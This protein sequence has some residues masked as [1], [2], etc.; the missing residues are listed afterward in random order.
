VNRIKGPPINPH[1]MVIW[2][3][4][5]ISS[6]LLSVRSNR[7]VR[8]QRSGKGIDFSFVLYPIPFPCALGSDLSV[9]VDNEL[10]RR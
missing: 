9:S 1:F 8:F 2:S 5:S 6:V 4:W 7:R 10:R 3:V